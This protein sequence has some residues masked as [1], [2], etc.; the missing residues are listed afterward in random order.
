MGLSG[1]SVVY[2]VGGVLLLAMLVLVAVVT[3]PG[4]VGGD[5]AY[6]V[7]SNSMEPTIEAGDV[8]VT[9]A[10][11]PDEIES[12]DV[13]TF[14]ADGV[15]DRGYV[16]HRVVEVREEN[17]ERYFKTKGD[18]N[19]DPDQGYVPASAAHGVQHLHIPYLGY[20]LLFARS[21]LGLVV[22]VI[23]PGL[24]LVASGSM[25]LL[26]EFGY[27]PDGGLL[28][29]LHGTDSDGGPPPA[30]EG[31]TDMAPVLKA[32]VDDATALEEALDDGT[33]SEGDQ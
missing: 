18:A 16:T 26:R 3:V 22:L 24:G 13:V 32:G 5:D 12:G 7:T 6:I 20:L 10:V 23:L 2:T 11:S 14:N 1:K 29:A 17:G 31:E 33:D 21:T 4:I 8:V 19:E 25:Q 27:T 30:L 15:A 9:K 28:A